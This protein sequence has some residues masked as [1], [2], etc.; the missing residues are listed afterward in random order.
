MSEP[1]Q[2]KAEPKWKMKYDADEKSYISYRLIS[3]S[4]AEAHLDNYSKQLG[5][6]QANV[7]IWTAVRDGQ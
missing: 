1:E 4:E 2:T 7:T 6:L 3:K 5:E